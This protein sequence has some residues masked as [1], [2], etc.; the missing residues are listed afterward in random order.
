[1]T[2]DLD[3]AL[4]YRNETLRNR[5]LNGAMMVSQENGA[6]AV[7][8]DQTYPVD[9][10]LVR[11]STSTGTFSLAQVA[12]VSPAGSPNRLR[13]TV[14]AADTSIA[15]GE[16]AG[17]W[18]YIEGSRI[19][20]LQL[21]TAWASVKTITLRFGVKAPAGI[22]CVSFRNSAVDRSYIAEY[23][24]A[25][26]EANTDVYKSVTIPLDQS[27]TWPKDT[28]IGLRVAFTLAV[29]STY[30]TAAGAWV[31]GNFIGSANQF[32]FFGTNANV[33]ELYDVSLTEGSVA[34]PFQVPDFVDELAKCKRY[35]EKSYDYATALGTVTNVGDEGNAIQMSSATAILVGVHCRFKQPKRALPTVTSYSPSTGAS[36]KARDAGN[37]VDVTPTV[38]HVGENGARIY[39]TI[40]AQSTAVIFAHWKADARL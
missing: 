32:N 1:M 4:S 26:G 35:W 24:I 37:G 33:F 28:G 30:Q 14:T 13:F 22:Y 23:T 31:A 10:W 27:G 38:D 36:G 7:T 16:F 18:Q 9:Q 2:I 39:I 34:P 25:P 11:N 20:D 40:S 19:A 15:A 3:R 5:L 17:I 8:G 12:S 21:G 29:G 6:T